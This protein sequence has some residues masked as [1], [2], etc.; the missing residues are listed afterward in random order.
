M[1]QTQ[2]KSKPEALRELIYGI[3]KNQ[4]MRADELVVCLWSEPHNIPCSDFYS[5][6]DVLKALNREG[7]LRVSFESSG[8]GLKITPAFWVV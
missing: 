6:I 8:S 7:H 3:L 2:V 4:T 1:S 5:I